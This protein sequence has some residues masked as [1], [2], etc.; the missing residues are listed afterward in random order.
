[1]DGI[2]YLP[3]YWPFSI[4]GLA[5]TILT[6]AAAPACV[7]EKLGSIASLRRSLVLTRG[8]RIPIM[9]I[10]L[11]GFVVVAAIIGIGTALAVGLASP[12]A[13]PV[14]RDVLLLVAVISAAIGLVIILA[15]GTILGLLPTVLYLK[16]RAIEAGRATRGGQGEIITAAAQP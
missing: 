1:M 4:V 6:I 8:N 16:L 13:T 14:Q 2:S 9:G 10:G 15:L 5:V 7:I 3:R 12:E 11:L